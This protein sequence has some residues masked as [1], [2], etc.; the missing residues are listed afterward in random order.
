MYI[1]A[2]RNHLN[3]V[4][5][6]SEDSLENNTLDIQIFNNRI[7]INKRNSCENLCVEKNESLDQVQ[8]MSEDALL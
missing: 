1:C 6:V 2:Q 3:D 8:W 4:T 7:Q 5:C